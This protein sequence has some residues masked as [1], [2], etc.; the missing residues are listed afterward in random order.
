MDMNRDIFAE[1]SYGKAALQKM[2]P[3]PENFRLTRSEWLGDKPV[4]WHIMKVTGA[5][6]RV[7]K[8]GPNAGKL[9]IPLKG[10]SRTAYVTRE[11]ILKMDQADGSGEHPDRIARPQ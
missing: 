10:T 3:V 9:S 1:Q 2:G 8:K 11:E 6:F 4:D 7:A 5:E